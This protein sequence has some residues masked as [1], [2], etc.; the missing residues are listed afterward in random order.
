MCI[1]GRF[2]GNGAEAETQRCVEPCRTDPAVV[3]ADL[4]T[5]AVFQVQLP[6][7]AA[8][9]RGC[10][11]AFSRRAIEFGVRAL[12][13]QLIGGGERGHGRFLAVVSGQWSVEW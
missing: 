2:A 10:S 12:E 11:R 9:Q 8:C 3:Q 6:V 5:L 7:V 13:E 1:A 4:L